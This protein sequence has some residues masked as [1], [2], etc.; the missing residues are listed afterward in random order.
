MK[1]Q[2]KKDRKKDVAWV[3]RWLDLGEDVGMRLALSYR[4]RQARKI[5]TSCIPV[6]TRRLCQS[7]RLTVAILDVILLLAGNF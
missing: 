5:G 4:R 2:Q 3:E 1:A 6:I 7:L